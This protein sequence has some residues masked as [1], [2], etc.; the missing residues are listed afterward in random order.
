MLENGQITTSKNRFYL[1]CPFLFGG[2]FDKRSVLE[3]TVDKLSSFRLILLA[4]NFYF[5]A[6]HTNVALECNV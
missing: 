2:N 4:M 6:L 1:R 3:G 5:G